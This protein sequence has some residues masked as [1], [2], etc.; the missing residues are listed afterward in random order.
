MIINI[1]EIA[2]GSINLEPVNETEKFWKKPMPER[3]RKL[4]QFNLCLLFLVVL[5][6]LL[7]I[8][9][10]ISYAIG[11]SSWPPSFRLYRWMYLY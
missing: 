2:N 5:A 10:P 8:G 7:V 9:V 4:W 6:V 11:I 3:R 1:V